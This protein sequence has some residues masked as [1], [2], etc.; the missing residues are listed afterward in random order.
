[1]LRTKVSVD[2]AIRQLNDWEREQIPFAAAMA[3]NDTVAEGRTEAQ[4]G[5][6]RDLKSPPTPWT[7]RGILFRRASK[8]RLEGA[9]Y[10]E[11]KRW[12]YLQYQIEGGTRRPRRRW[13]MIGLGRR[14]QY[15]NIPGWRNKRT[16]LL[17]RSDHFEGEVRGTVGIWQR[18]KR[19]LKLIVAY[20]KQ[21]R[22]EPRWRFFHRAERHIENRY[23]IL[24]R[25]R[26]ERALETAR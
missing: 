9:L 7:Q 14:N 22:Y 21:A 10:I 4:K 12:E 1:M 6:R 25:R 11:A 19:G 24:F 17:A 26:M 16:R 2:D 20:R 13:I 23:P 3:I 5:M 18:Q 8:R 15:G